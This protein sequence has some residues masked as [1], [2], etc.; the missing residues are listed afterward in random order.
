MR[1][2]LFDTVLR[3][4][5]PDFLF[6]LFVVCEFDGADKY[7]DRMLGSA[8]PI[9]YGLCKDCDCESPVVISISDVVQEG[10]A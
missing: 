8:I 5:P 7:T 1:L 6:P 3:C 10:F 2:F 4:L 9:R